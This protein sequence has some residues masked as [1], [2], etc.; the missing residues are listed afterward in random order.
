MRK[1]KKGRRCVKR[2]KAF[3]SGQNKK[4][5]YKRVK[6]IELNVPE[7]RLLCTLLTQTGCVSYDR[8]GILIDTKSGI[9][10]NTLSPCYFGGSDKRLFLLCYGELELL[11]D[12]LRNGLGPG[13]CRFVGIDVCK[14]LICKIEHTITD[15][16][17]DYAFG[18]PCHY[19]GRYG[20][21]KTVSDVLGN[22]HLLNVRFASGVCATSSASNIS[23]F[24]D[25]V[26]TI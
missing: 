26:D 16:A 25:P 19:D 17:V 6:L 2:D 7:R 23:F 21:V 1:I 5:L 11:A 14:D 10:L 12:L 4:E 24:R 22:G 18:Q 13:V 9:L 20:P 3:P 15:I 8:E